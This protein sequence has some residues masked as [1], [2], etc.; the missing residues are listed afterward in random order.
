MIA[1]KIRLH[2]YS[3]ISLIRYRLFGRAYRNT[4]G[5]VI[6]RVT[7]RVNKQGKEELHTYLRSSD[8]EIDCAGALISFG[9]LIDF[10]V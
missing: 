3:K 4:N 6:S 9:Y 10:L 8:Q 1:G 7:C 5:I 2:D